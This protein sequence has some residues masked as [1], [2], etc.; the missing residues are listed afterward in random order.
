MG[1]FFKDL[2][3][4]VRSLV[5]HPASTAA[6][7]MSLAVG[8]GASLTIFS[9]INGMVLR[10][11]PVEDPDRLVSVYTKEPPQL[12]LN[13]ISLPNYRDLRARNETLSGLLAWRIQRFNVKVDGEAV[14]LFGKLVSGDY[15]DVLGVSAA[16]GRT[17][18]PS[19]AAASGDPPPV[20]VL[21]HDFW[22]RLFGEDPGFLGRAVE[23][24]GVALTVVG[25]MP[26]GFHGPTRFRA[27]TVLWVPWTL[28]EQ[29]LPNVSPAV[30][31][32]RSL[33]W[34]AI[35]RLKPGL[36]LA[37]AEAELV[38]LFAQ[39]AEEHPEDNAGRGV[40]LFPL[41]EVDFSPSPQDRA[42]AYRI[43]A[44]LLVMAGSVLVIACAN[45]AHL[46]LARHALRGPETA[47]RLAVGA[48]RRHLIR[49]L[50]AEGVPLVL[51]GAAAG[52]LLARW[53][54]D[55]LLAV[56][57][58]R[59]PGAL[60]LSFDARVAAFALGLSVLSLV[61][62]VLA[63]A[64]AAMRPRTVAELK[65]LG[66]WRHGRRRGRPGSL[67]VVGQVALSLVTL[68]FTGLFARGLEVLREIDPGFDAGKLAVAWLDLSALSPETG[69][70]LSQ[71]LLERIAALPGVEAAALAKNAPLNGEM[72]RVV[73][74][75]DEENDG[76]R[77]VW[78]NATTAG[79]FETLGVSLVRGRTFRADDPPAVVVNE[80]LAETF[81]PGEEAVGRRLRFHSET[82]SREVLGVVRDSK[83]RSMLDSDEPYAFYPLVA[84]SLSALDLLVRTGA[85]PAAGLADLRQA[86]QEL[87]PELVVTGVLTMPEL[88]ES[89]L[90][91]F[92]VVTVVLSV[93]SFL[94][95]ALAAAGLFGVMSYSVSRRHREIGIRMAVGAR[96][97]EIVRLIVAQGMRRIGVGLAVGLAV[98]LSAAW[99][100][101]TSLYGIRLT[102][103]VTYVVASLFLAAVALAAI[104]LPVRQATALEPSATLRDE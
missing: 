104:V 26:E 93:V 53:G 35:G 50:V 81:W 47:I 79:Y 6:A 10:P 8:L 82:E 31:G 77:L 61:L 97:S 98:C 62:I 71:R 52:L 25:V 18:Q 57:G 94:A 84:G 87:E 69:L 1:S 23:V 29:L 42:V 63:P 89:S 22:V 17:L 73:Y 36:D 2:H 20:V 32:R 12:W 70:T 67:L 40:E 95:L 65:D 44:L 96:P 30:F 21:H 14:P 76:G 101:K 24:N 103:P 13:E 91:G 56:L 11:L 19:D 38:A 74:L 7:S 46:F 43:L 27:G 37:T 51:L 64:L 54:H 68:I 78:C 99:L 80:T 48:R 83:E 16:A 88:V 39:L 5:R 45:V 59:A 49:Q 9:L 86:V 33:S 72:Y 75:E 100:L 58:P 60:D 92:R 90:A 41:G 102:D 55:L 85:D 28:H 3:R 34:H 15:F 4:A 66:P